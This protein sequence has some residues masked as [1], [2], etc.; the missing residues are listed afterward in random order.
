MATE[1]SM[2]DLKA[3]LDENDLDLSMRQLT[4]IPA[5]ALV[6]VFSNNIL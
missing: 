1:L 6:S 5:K 3:L 2:K 4:T